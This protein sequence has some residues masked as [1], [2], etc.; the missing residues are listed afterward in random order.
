MEI[1]SKNSRRKTG[2]TDAVL[3]RLTSAPE[4]AH[5][6]YELAESLYLRDSGGNSARM[7][8]A[9]IERI[10]EYLREI[11]MDD[12]RMKKQF[13]DLATTEGSFYPEKIPIGF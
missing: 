9:D 3:R 2:A 7:T 12:K 10:G 6:I 4:T 8:L 13:A 11:E 5:R 1:K